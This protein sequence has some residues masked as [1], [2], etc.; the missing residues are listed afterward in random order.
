MFGEN[1]WHWSHS[2][3]NIP[4]WGL[5]EIRICLMYVF[6]KSLHVTPLRVALIPQGVCIANTAKKKKHLYNFW[7]PGSQNRGAVLCTLSASDFPSGKISSLRNS[8]IKSIQ[9]GPT[10]ICRIWWI[11][12]ITLFI[13]IGLHKS[14]TRITWGKLCVEE[15]ARMAKELACVFS[16]LGICNKLKDLNLDCKCLT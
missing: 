9:L 5:C 1:L 8:T 3:T 16:L 6:C 10:R 15:I 2:A 14:S 12:T 7:S 11:W 4:K 13:L